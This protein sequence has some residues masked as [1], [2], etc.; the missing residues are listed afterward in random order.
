MHGICM[1]V[2]I[3]RY[4]GR[5][6]GRCGRRVDVP[7]DGDGDGREAER[8]TGGKSTSVFHINSSYNEFRILMSS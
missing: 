6:G 8:T 5:D 1:N 4:I 3:G 2:A 7:R